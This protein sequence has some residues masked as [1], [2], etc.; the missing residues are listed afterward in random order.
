MTSEIELL[1][2]RL[3]SELGTNYGKP[4]FQWRYSPEVFYYMR[5]ETALSFS[6]YC[7]ADQIGKVWMLCQS[8]PI[9]W[10]DFDGQ[11]HPITREAWWHSF[12]GEFPYPDRGMDVAHTE[13]A[14]APG[15][16]PDGEETAVWIASIKVQMEKTEAMHA[17]ATMERMAKAREDNEKE[18][19]EMADDSFPAFWKNGIGHEAGKRGAHVSFGGL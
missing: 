19:M 17:A 5:G 15:I 18:F 11:V 7:W 14:L 4:R 8:A 10:I 12:K 9:Q 1:N 6:R 13:T 3:E 16:L 2:K